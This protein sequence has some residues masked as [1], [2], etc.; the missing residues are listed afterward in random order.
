MT[1][2]SFGNT[3]PSRVNDN[4]EDAATNDVP[5]FMEQ[6]ETYAAYKIASYINQYWFPVL[7]PVGLVGNTLSFLVMIKPNNRKVSTCIFM[8]AISINDNLMMCLSFHNWLVNVVKMHPWHLWECKTM[9]YLF[10]IALQSS[11]YQVLAMTFD[12]Y[13]AIKWPHRAATYSTSKRVNI[14]II[15]LYVFSIIYNSIVFFITGLNRGDCSLVLLNET[16]ARVHNVYTWITFVIDG[17]IPLSLLIYMNTVIVQTVRK[18]RKMFKE[19]RTNTKMVNSPFRNKGTD[20]RQ[21]K[22]QN[23]E[24]QL[25]IMLLMVSILFTILLIP[26]Y[27]RTVFVNFFKI[28]SPSKYASYY[29]FF[30]MTIKLAST[31]NGINFFLYCISGNRF[32]ED[33]KEILL[34]IGRLCGLSATPVVSGISDSHSDCTNISVIRSNF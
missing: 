27:V 16:T 22:M 11:I 29:L 3:D 21:R 9:A 24:N 28:D 15:I 2:D 12:K 25:T 1:N 31:N 8:A 13:L 18:S 4:K 23:A 32:R 14:F 34:G 33:L 20:T 7:I 10:R 5:S 26:T 19:N 6:V 17:I 30:Q